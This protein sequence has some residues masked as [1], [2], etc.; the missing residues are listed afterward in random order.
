MLMVVDVEGW[1]AKH[2]KVGCGRVHVVSKL[3]W[4]TGEQRWRRRVLTAKSKHV[5]IGHGVM[6]T[7]D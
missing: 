6:A 3:W 2:V 4:T 7:D 5:E 1:R